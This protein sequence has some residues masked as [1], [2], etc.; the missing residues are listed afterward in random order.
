MDF[1]IVFATQ[2]NTLWL[3]PSMSS[4]ELHQIT[5]SAY[6]TDLTTYNNDKS[7]H[8]FTIRN[9][10]QILAFLMT[11]QQ[12]SDIKMPSRAVFLATMDNIHT[13]YDNDVVGNIALQAAAKKEEMERRW[14]VTRFLTRR[15]HA[16]IEQEER[17]ILIS[18]LDPAWAADRATKTTHLHIKGSLE[19]GPIY[20][21]LARLDTALIP[22]IAVTFD[23]VNYRNEAMMVLH[24]HNLTLP[25][26]MFDVRPYEKSASLN[27]IWHFEWTSLNLHRLVRLANEMLRSA[28]YVPTYMLYEH[29][30]EGD[31]AGDDG[32]MVNIGGCSPTWLL[33]MVS[34]GVRANDWRLTASERGSCTLCYEDHAGDEMRSASDPRQENRI[35]TVKP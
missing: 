14:D 24:A 28:S 4:S 19:A 12:E 27:T 22:S 30:V 5:P 35:R 31:E 23:S 29:V 6:I 8:A 9:V 1:P 11:K 18:Q 13:T 10:L 34:T 17:T 20:V 26:P 33:N 3:L 15:Y 2:D 25:S 21:R 16:S 32:L 7:W